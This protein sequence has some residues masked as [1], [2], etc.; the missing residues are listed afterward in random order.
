VLKIKSMHHIAIMRKSWGLLPKILTGEKTVESR[1]YKNKYAPWDKI[2]QG[3]IVYFKDSGELVTI[4]AEVSKILQ[5]ENLTKQKTKEILD[6][7][8]QAD[9]GVDKL[10][11]EIKD[12]VAD[13]NYCILIF[14]KNPKK[15]KPFNIN[16]SGFGA[17]ASW[18]CV[19]NIAK[20]KIES[21]QL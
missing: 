18:I 3:D 17:M 5:F 14:F 9:L 4:K 16:K 8:A 2:K 6:K 11:P 1:W 12:Y 13:K 15:I 20:I 19:K 21:C 7:Y 10:T